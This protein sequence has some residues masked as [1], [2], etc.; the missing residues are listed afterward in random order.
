MIPEVLRLDATAQAALIRNREL[1]ASELVE[2]SIAQIERFNPQ[3][4]AIITPLYEGARRQALNPVDGAFMGVPL[5]L[6][7]FMCQTAGDPYYAG[8][9]YLRDLAWRSKADTYLARRFREAGFIFIGKSNLPELALSPTTEPLAFGATRNPYQLDH[10]AGGSSGGSAAAVATR[11]VAVAHA[12]DGYGSIRIPASCCGLVGLKPS[13]GRIS[14]GPAYSGGLLGNIVE[15]VVV[16]SV[17]DAANIL[18]AIHGN[19]PGD[20]FVAPPLLTDPATGK[21]KLRVGLLTHDPFLPQDVHPDCVAAVEKTGKL[22][23]SVGHHVEYSYP[24]A[25]EGPTGLGLALR[26]ISSSRLAASLDEL[27]ELTGKPITADDVE[28]ATWQAAEEGRTFSAVQIHAAQRRLLNGICRTPEWWTNYDLLITPTMTQPPPPLGSDPAEHG[29]IFGLFCMAIS[30][31]GLPAISLPLHW[32]AD[33]LPIGV[34]LVANLGREDLLLHIGAQ[35]EQLASW[36]DRV[37]ALI[38]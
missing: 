11:M 24:P 25:F 21:T 6:K 37:P 23:E 36:A 31:A 26:I 3:I 8:M 10:S 15:F 28:P 18:Q 22:L 4:N 32:T 17:R 19:M 29:L 27:A 5:V 12:N 14:T 13:R 34:Q 38:S 30:V 2:A 9:R 1:S 20:L 16:R 33:D 7:D 35:L